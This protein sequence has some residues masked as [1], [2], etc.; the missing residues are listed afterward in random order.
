[1][2]NLRRLFSA[3]TTTCMI[4][5][6]FSCQKEQDSVP[7]HV[8]TAKAKQGLIAK[9]LNDTEFV[10]AVAKN[11]ASFEDKKIDL[12]EGR[13]NLDAL[14]DGLDAKYPDLA[15]LSDTDKG[16][17]L[18]EVYNSIPGQLAQSSDTVVSKRS[19]LR[20]RVMI[21]G[22]LRW[23]MCDNTHWCCMIARRLRKLQ[24]ACL[25]EHCVRYKLCL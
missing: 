23:L 15:A 11:Y 9:I 21:R 1:M 20:R 10:G 13:L 19:Y 25:A 8:D 18:S 14:I 5:V 16:E 4:L 22:K 3:V 12:S 17:I 6:L 7:Q 24:R 2:K